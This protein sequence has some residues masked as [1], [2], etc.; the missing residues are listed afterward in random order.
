MYMYTCMYLYVV[1]IIQ[2]GEDG[3]I[4]S[5]EY[6]PFELGRKQKSVTYFS[7]C[8]PYSYS[9]CQKYLNKI[10]KQLLCQQDSNIM[11][12]SIYYH[13]Q[14]LCNSLDGLRI[15][16]LTISSYHGITMETEPHL[17]GLYP[18][19]S[20]ERARVF[21]NKKVQNK[22]TDLISSIILQMPHYNYMYT[23]LSISSCE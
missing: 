6:T 9:E 10:D 21:E 3:M 22:M 15:D 16:L 23:I 14:L 5:F 20:E 1:C 4:L 12:E 2:M 11:E 7:F 17:P 13:R 18:D 19:V 8:Y